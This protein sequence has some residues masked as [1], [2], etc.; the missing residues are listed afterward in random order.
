MCPWCLERAGAQVSTISM[1]GACTQQFWGYEKSWR[2]VC[3]MAKAFALHVP[4]M[5]RVTCTSI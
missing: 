5:L 3:P 1:W 2:L 4:H